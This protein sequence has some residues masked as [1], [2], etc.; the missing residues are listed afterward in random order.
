MDVGMNKLTCCGGSFTKACGD[1]DVLLFACSGAANA[2]E[3]ADRAAR[4]ISSEKRA[5]LFCLAAIAAGR[6]DSISEARRARLIIVVDGCPIDCGARVF[7][8]AG[9]LDFAHLR[10]TDLDIQKHGG[11]GPLPDGQV[12]AAASLIRRWIE[13]APDHPTTQGVRVVRKIEILG[14]GCPKCKSLEQSA[15]AAVEHL[16]I[17]A[18]ITKV[19]QMDAIVARGVMMTP[20]IAVDGVVKSSG[21]VLSPAEIEKLLA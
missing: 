20:A 15:R 8:S 14:T 9:L 3:I 2:G 13:E 11:R 10:V 17:E 1:G 4:R 7:E 21:R 18:E 16:G 6:P 5:G 19:D 12:E